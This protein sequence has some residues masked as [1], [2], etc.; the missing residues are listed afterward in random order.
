MVNPRNG[1]LFEYFME[2]IDFIDPSTNQ[3]RAL[4]SILCVLIYTL[5]TAIFLVQCIY[6]FRINQLL[7]LANIFKIS[8]VIEILLKLLIYSFKKIIQ[9]IS[10]IFK[11]LIY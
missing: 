10:I 9:I 8:Q 5:F 7:K 11:T 3:Q 6:L 2:L 1:S 4:F